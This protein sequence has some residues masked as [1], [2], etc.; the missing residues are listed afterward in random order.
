M[1]RFSVLQ[2]IAR[3]SFFFCPYPSSPSFQETFFSLQLQ[4]HSVR[5]VLA[6]LPTCACLQ[7]AAPWVLDGPWRAI[8]QFSFLSLSFPLSQ[9]GPN[10][11]LFLL[12]SCR[13]EEYYDTT[14][15]KILQ[16]APLFSVQQL[17]TKLTKYCYYELQGKIMP[18]VHRL[19]PCYCEGSFLTPWCYLQGRSTLRI[20]LPHLTTFLLYS[21]LSLSFPSLFHDAG[22]VPATV[23]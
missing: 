9:L 8:W 4:E 16:N 18:V 6:V 5:W 22:F 21:I 10:L 7:G 13:T 3:S 2:W 12:T 1:G 20:S 15:L 19:L 17:W 14:T 23:C 11:F